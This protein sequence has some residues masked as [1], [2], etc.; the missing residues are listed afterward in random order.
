[1]D[2]SYSDFLEAP[3]SPSSLFVELF[4]SDYYSTPPQPSSSSTMPS[5]NSSF[6]LPAGPT[7]TNQTAAAVVPA[8]GPAAAAQV[9]LQVRGSAGYR[10]A[11]QRIARRAAVSRVHAMIPAEREQFT[12]EQV[13][14]ATDKFS[15]VREANNKS[16][17]RARFKKMATTVALADETLRLNG[18]V[19]RLRAIIARHTLGGAASSSMPRGSLN[20]G[21][22]SL[23]GPMSYSPDFGLGLNGMTNTLGGPTMPNPYALSAM[24]SSLSLPAA[25]NNADDNNPPLPPC[26]TDH[27]VVDRGLVQDARD[28]RKQLIDAL[29]TDKIRPLEFGCHEEIEG[30]IVRGREIRRLLGVADEQ[31]DRWV[32]PVEGAPSTN[33]GRRRRREREDDGGEDGSDDEYVDGGKKGKGKGKKRAR[34][35]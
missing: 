29:L 33:G 32:P 9:P 22:G 7:T 2:A 26:P 19:A 15:K 35:A 6:S 5:Q 4:G 27:L 34:K 30:I 20:L 3:G 12:E 17:K 16:A 31:W 21:M 14:E 25:D 10:H 18:E 28:C 24:S 1:M 8:T 13:R 23:L 11:L